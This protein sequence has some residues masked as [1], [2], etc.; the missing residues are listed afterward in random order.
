MSIHMSQHGEALVTAKFHAA[1]H[2]SA[3]QAF[4][5]LIKVL[6]HG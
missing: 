1:Q 4:R 3:R 5:P 6:R 2:G